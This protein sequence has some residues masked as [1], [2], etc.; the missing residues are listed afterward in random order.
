MQKIANILKV[1]SISLLISLHS[2]QAYSSERIIEVS[3]TEKISYKT[4][5]ATIEFDIVGRG[6]NT[7][8]SYNDYA[9]RSLNVITYLRSETNEVSNLQTKS[10]E[11]RPVYNIDSKNRE[12]IGYDTISAASFKVSVENVPIY[13]NF[14]SQNN[15]DRITNIKFSIDDDLLEEK[16]EQAVK[17]AIDKALNKADSVLKQLELK[18]K[19]VVKIELDTQNVNYPKFDYQIRGQALTSDVNPIIIPKDQEV[20]A[21][22]KLEIAY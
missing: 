19:A 10:F 3:A 2:F 9:T 1:I 13:L 14:L 7:E 5:H 21:S 16:K 4:T 20:E 15:I 8:I 18:R 6:P 12:I 17:L 11:S 22:V